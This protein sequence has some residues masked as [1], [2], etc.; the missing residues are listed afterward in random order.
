MGIGFLKAAKGFIFGLHP[1][2]ALIKGDYEIATGEQI[3]KTFENL[4]Y[5][6]V[7]MILVAGHGPFTWGNTL[8]KAVYNGVILEELA[9]M[10]FLTLQINPNAKRLKDPLLPLA[11][12]VSR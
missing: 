11:S 7:E 6:E 2:D 1:I 10:A 5:E 3:I 12:F 4:S 9:K 8:E